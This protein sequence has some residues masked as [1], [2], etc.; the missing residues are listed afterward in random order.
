[1]NR[2]VL[3]AAAGVLGLGLII[4]PEIH[5]GDI[6]A[7]ELVQHLGT[8]LLIAAILGVTIDYWF[9]HQIAKDVFEAA[10]GYLLPEELREEM[11]YIYA[12]SLFCERHI[13][14]LQITTLDD[15]R[16]VL[17]VTTE[18]L[19]INTKNKAETMSLSLRFDEWHESRRSRLV[20]YC[21]KH[22]DSDEV[23]VDVASAKPVETGIELVIPT[24]IVLK[25]GDRLRVRH[26]Y[27]EIKRRNGSHVTT[28]RY[29]TKTPR[30]EVQTCEGLK[31]EVGFSNRPNAERD[32][33]PGVATLSG[34]LLPHQY[35]EVRWWDT[36]QSAQ[37]TRGASSQSDASPSA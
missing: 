35:I 29:P 28:F 4:I 2:W 9:K 23:C 25:H 11:R 32:V 27:E 18:R 14:R 33:Y 30:V 5:A 8:A 24:Q 12:H 22:N 1:M 19:F 17:A 36:A 10:V 37:F 21:Y 31:Y 7:G 20:E 34:V 16:V 13:Q 6:Q 3:I 15:E 26:T